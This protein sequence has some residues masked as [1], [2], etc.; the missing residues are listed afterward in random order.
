MEVTNVEG[1]GERGDGDEATGTFFFLNPIWAIR[2]DHLEV[3]TEN[4]DST[5]VLAASPRS[6]AVSVHFFDT[7]SQYASGYDNSGDRASLADGQGGLTSYTYDVRDELT[8]VKQSGTGVL[9]KR[10]DFAYDTAGRMTTLTRYSD[11]TG[12][13]V[14][15]QSTYAYNPIGW[16]TAITDKTSGGTTRAAYT[17]SYDQAGNVTSESRTWTVGGG[18]S[19]DTVTYAYTNN[20]QLTGVTHTNGAYAN[21]SFGYDANGNRNTTGYSTGTNNRLSADGTYTYAYDDEGNLT[22]RT[23][24]SDGSQTLYAYDYR[25]RLTEV[26]AKVGGVTTVLATYTYD[27]LDRRIGI[28]EAGATTWTVFDG[29]TTDPL[30]DFN[31][32]G[33]QTARYLNGPQGNLVD[34]LLARET[35]GGVAWYLPDRLGSVKDLVDN[36]GVVV[37]HI[38]YNAYG[39]TTNE[40]APS[41]GD[42]FGFAWLV[43][44]PATGLNLAVRRTQD[45]ISGRW[46]SE[47]PI[48]F[49]GGDANLYRYVNNRPASALDPSGTEIYLVPSSVYGLGNHYSIIVYDP[50]SGTGIQYDGGGAGTCGVSGSG[51]RKPKPRWTSLGPNVKPGPNWILVPSP[52]SPFQQQTNLSTAYNKMRQIPDYNASLGPNSNTFANQLLQNAG[53]SAKKPPNAPGWGYKGQSCY[54]GPLY[55]SNGKPTLMPHPGGPP[56]IIMGPGI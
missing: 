47:D 10:A 31:G 16:L 53:Y 25:N 40:T 9:A 48:G 43:R 1:H 3:V 35:S 33:S 2:E 18:T 41:A 15:Q 44:D 55:D 42:R 30:L 20:D 5:R 23:K 19:T 4:G 29:T 28:A 13:T 56:Y 34:A 17:D 37:D 46:T 8:T 38:D 52:G 39:K 45:P 21:E 11:T 14:A 12:T 26:D 24:A 27:A 22:A 36:T 49:E 7:S 32:S 54:G 51:S 50:A 6:C